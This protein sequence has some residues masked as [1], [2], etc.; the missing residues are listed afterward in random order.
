MFKLTALVHVYNIDIKVLVI[1]R[2]G[3]RTMLV[4]TQN[5]LTVGVCRSERE[6]FD[7]LLPGKSFI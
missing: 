4:Y 1:S 6:A 3:L 2:K 5:L 7:V